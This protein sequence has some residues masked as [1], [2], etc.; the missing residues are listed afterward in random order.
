QYMRPKHPDII[1]IDEELARTERLIETFRKQSVEQLQSRR[2]AIGLQMQN[3]ERA[4]KEWETKAVDLSRKLAEHDRIKAN[5]DRLQAIADRLSTNL[6]NVDMTQAVE[7]DMI[8]ILEKASESLSIRP[9]LVKVLLIGLGAGLVTGFAILFLMERLDDRVTSILDV[10]NHF[11]E[12]ILG[13]VVHEDHVA[14]TLQLLQHEDERHSFAESFRSV[15]SSILYLPKSRPKSILITSAIPGEGKS[16]VSSNLA[17]A[18]ALAGAKTI[19]IDADL[20]RG[21]VHKSFGVSNEGGL[22]EILRDLVPWSE[23]VKP[24]HMAN[25][26]VI[27]RGSNLPHP[28]EHLLAPITDRFLEEVYNKYDYVIIDSAPVMVAEDTPSLAPKIDAVAVVMRFSVSSSRLTRR[29]V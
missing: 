16:T 11:G 23:V 14:G 10:Q 29:T 27:T 7:Q 12:K 5:V 21:G 3:L 18:F 17:I 4:V 1:R 20:R 9:G 19:L 26:S 13:Q 22:S 25:L 8:S 2:E 24:T 6:R 15:R 28:S